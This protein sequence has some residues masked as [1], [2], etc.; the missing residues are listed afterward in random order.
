MIKLKKIK[1]KN[2]CGYKDFELDLTEGD[3]VKKWLMF[4]GP[5]G[6]FKSTFLNAVMLLATP[7]IF[8]QKKN[9]LVFRK[10]KYHHDYFSGVE[11][12]YD[13]INDLKME[14]TFLSK[15][16]EKKVILED[17]IRG[18]IFAGRKVNTEKGEI[19]GIRTNE[20]LPNEQGVIFI[21]ADSRNMMHKFQIIDGLHEEFCDFASSIY[22]FKCYCPK[23][24][25]VID[26]GIKYRLDF[27]I[28]KP[29]GTKVHYKRFSDGEKKIA[30]LV[31]SLFKRAY[32]NSPDKEN[33]DIICVDNI[34]QHIYY[35]RH[36]LLIQK[37]EEY[38]SD[39]QIIATTHSPIIIENMDKRYLINMENI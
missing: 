33:K 13:Q 17:N 15:K 8:I 36:M 31:S 4:Y 37:I 5:N 21:D 19:S 32:K 9:I 34:E 20:L 6:S 14:A 24:T 18:V 29:N 2:Y 3:G 26:H 16:G 35:K 23:K 28:E 1:L 25:I 39:K 11:T 30:T 12:L 38:F 10:L 7:K 27:V 22:G